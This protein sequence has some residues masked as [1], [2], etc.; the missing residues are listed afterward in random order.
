[1]TDV[2][3]PGRVFGPNALALNMLPPGSGSVGPQGPAG[4]PGPPGATGPQGDPG[5]Q[6]APGV[7][8]PPLNFQF[9]RLN[10]GILFP[11]NG[12]H[13]A[14]DGAFVNLPPAN[15]VSNTGRVRWYS[16]IVGSPEAD[17]YAGVL[18]ISNGQLRGA[19][20]FADRVSYPPNF[21]YIVA[22]QAGE[23]TVPGGPSVV[24]DFMANTQKVSAP[25]NTLLIQ[26]Y[27][28]ECFDV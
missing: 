16:A 2:N 7:N 5:P 17:G 8:A 26:G 22:C 28:W 19:L 18:S 1:M 13:L 23:M 12:I 4:P 6:G 20:A 14:G 24:Q 27:Y 25:G 15:I 9:D 3:T 21:N 11:P 10:L